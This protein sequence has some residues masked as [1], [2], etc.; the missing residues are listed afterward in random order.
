MRSLTSIALAAL[1][2]SAA[3]VHAQ[4][5]VTGD[6]DVTFES[7][8]GPMTVTVSLTT[9]GGKAS[10]Q[11]A[12]PMGKVPLAGTTTADSFD[13]TATLD[14]QG[15]PLPLGL[16]G[17][18]NGD[19]LTGNIKAGD[20][21]QFPFTGKRAT[22][23]ATTPIAPVGSGAVAAGVPD[24][25][26]GTWNI[27]LDLGGNQ[28]PITATFKQDGDKI[29]GRLSGPA[30]E[31]AANGVLTGKS[32][33]L[34]FTVQTPQGEVPVTMTGDLAADGTFVGKASIGGMGEAN[35]TGRR[36]N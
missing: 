34:E 15:T 1:V 26:S 21:G 23:Q 19:A 6:W 17:K 36:A 22:A 9:D 33:K 31:M 7:P 20:F 16:T 13:V 3:N 10:G 24:G 35:W 2:F 11:L 12:T 5:G 18:V 28:V 29:S 14:V 8:Q 27:V 30:G 32:L 4:S 25:A